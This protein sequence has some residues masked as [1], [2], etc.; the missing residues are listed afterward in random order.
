MLAVFRRSLNTWPV[1]VLFVLL[2]AAFGVWGIGDVLRNLGNDGSAAKVDGQAISP[3]QVAGAYRQQLE[4]ATQQMGGPDHVTA[5]MRMMLA[6]QATARLVA[7]AAIDHMARGMGLAAPNATVQQAVFGMDAFKGADGKFDKT[8]FD[9]VLQANGLS[10]TEFLH[11]MQGQIIRNQLLNSI[12]AAVTAPPVMV[13]TAYAFQNQTRTADLVQLPFAAAPAPAAPSDQVLQRWYKNHPSEF[14]APEYRRITL[15]ILSPEFLARDITVP[16][17]DVQAAY[18][19][20]VAETPPK[21]ETRTVDVVLAQDQKAAQAIAAQWQGGASWDAVQAAAK[22]AGAT[23]LDLPNITQAQVPSEALGEAAFKA[24]ADT[25]TGPVST[26][27]TS[28]AVFKVSNIQSGGA[29][30][31]YAEAAPGLRQTIARQRA[32]ALVNKRVNA[33]QD[34]LAG[35]T[36][37][38]K[39]PANL[40]LAALQGSID[41]S[42]LTEQGTPAP[43]PG[44]AAVRQAV[45]DQAFKQKVHE[46]AT[47]INGPDNS[48]FALTVDGITPATTKPYAAVEQQVLQSWTE[49][50]RRREQNVAAT[51]MLQAMKGGRT[52]QGVADA[53]GLTVTTTPALTRQG[54]VPDGVPQNLVAPLFSLDQGASTMIET[55]EGFVVAQLKSVNTPDPKA[56]PVGYDQLRASLSSALADDMQAVFAGV[57][58]ARA[59]PRINQAVIQQIAQP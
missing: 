33:L 35:R 42:G 54:Q 1:R 16:D 46:A 27:A 30:Q 19:R 37:L 2:I 50:E 31:S 28:W 24:K 11:L 52:L 34:A 56:D 53:K 22:A 10:E 47:L 25:V 13:K 26:G 44:T 39:L 57:V 8:Q 12:R 18:Q 6:E 20:M 45:V 5:E 15:V 23:S 36:P 58:T 14:S 40:G 7:Q 43:I 41:S 59:N 49:A 9:Q 48:Y 29:A 32:V 4:Q 21:P 51:A 38:E 17:A 55:P 3:Q